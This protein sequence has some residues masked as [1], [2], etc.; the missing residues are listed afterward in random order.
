MAAATYSRLQSPT[1]RMAR[2]PMIAPPERRRTAKPGL[3]VAACRTDAE[4]GETEVTAGIAQSFSEAVQ[5]MGTTLLPD[6]RHFFRLL[7]KFGH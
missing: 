6:A 5:E 2:P 7:W 3:A 1:C 4:Y